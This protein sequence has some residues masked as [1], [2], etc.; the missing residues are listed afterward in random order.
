MVAYVKQ[1]SGLI[2]KATLNGQG[3]VRFVLD[4]GATITVLSPRTAS[5][6]GLTGG[7]ERIMLRGVSGQ[8]QIARKCRLREL[9]LGG[10]KALNMEVVIHP[11][12]MLNERGIAGLLGQDFLDRFNLHFDSH[13]RVLTLTLPNQPKKAKKAKNEFEQRVDLV[14]E[15]PKAVWLDLSGFNTRLGDYYQAR[16]SQTEE[17]ALEDL[18]LLV[19]DL[20]KLWSRN[21]ALHDHLIN[22]PYQQLAA[23]Q[24]N[25]LQRFL[26]CYPVYAS[27]LKAARVLASQLMPGA[28]ALKKLT[29]DWHKMQ[30]AFAG[31]GN[32]S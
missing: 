4:T 5:R 21:K 26:Y 23:K 9:S 27:H 12:A 31:L 32:C 1:E 28:A 14:L 25:N 22:T 19:N 13:Q 18:I 6:L 11:I 24:N 3:P 30:A 10:A 29:A 17:P 7:S 16:A 2:V 8:G 15:N 20:A